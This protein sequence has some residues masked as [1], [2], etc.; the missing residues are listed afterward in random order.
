MGLAGGPRPGVA[1]GE[2][3]RLLV[4]QRL[5]RKHAEAV[6]CD[7]HDRAVVGS[8]GHHHASACPADSA[9]YGHTVQ[10]RARIAQLVRTVEPLLRQSAHH[11]IDTARPVDETVTA[12][13]A[14]F[15]PK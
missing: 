7:R 8:A 3:R 9:G 5:C 2:P 1:L 10:E 12:I 11:E 13:L 4:R 14:L 6:R 15:V